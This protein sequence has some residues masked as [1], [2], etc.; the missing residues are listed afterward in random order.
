MTD[1]EEQAEHEAKKERVTKRSCPIA[2]SQGR[3]GATS[4]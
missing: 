2:L 3:A 4:R 1:H